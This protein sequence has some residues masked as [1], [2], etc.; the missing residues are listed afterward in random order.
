[1]KNLTGKKIE[2]SQLAVAFICIIFLLQILKFG[3]PHDVFT[4]DTWG[5]YLYLPQTFLHGDPAISDFSNIQYVLDNYPPGDPN[6]LYQIHPLPNGNYV[7]QYWCGVSLLSL[8][9]FYIGHFAAWLLSYP[10]DGYS[11]PYQFAFIAGNL[12]YMVIGILMF[13]KLLLQFFNPKITGITL[14]IICLGTNYFNIHITGLGMTHIYLFVLYTCT[15]YCIVRFYR[16]FKNK[17]LYLASIFL[18]LIILVRAVDGLLVLIPFTW[19]LRNFKDLKRRITQLWALRTPLLIAFIIGTSIL[20]IQFIYFKAISGSFFINSYAN[21]EESLYLDEPHLFEFLFSFRK[22]WFIYTP[23]MIFYVLGMITLFKKARG[24]FFPIIV[25]SI[26]FIYVSSSWSTWWYGYSF[27][28]R[29]M[30]QTYPLLAIPIGAFFSKYLNKRSSTFGLTTILVFLIGLNAFQT[31]QFKE[32][33]LHGSRMSFGA[34]CAIFGRL[35]KPENLDDLLLVNRDGAV[36]EKENYQALTDFK[37]IFCMPDVLDK[38]NIYSHSLMVPFNATSNQYYAWYEIQFE[39]KIEEGSNAELP[40]FVGRFSQGSRQY[41]TRQYQLSASSNFK[42][43][44]WCQ[45]TFQYI[46][47][48]IRRNSDN[49]ECFIWGRGENVMVKNMVMTS[50]V[51]KS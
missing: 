21:P 11:Y 35:T 10:M 36:F 8:P 39:F 16:T 3:L 37:T 38:E 44:E 4:W 28:Q 17:Y 19:G 47:P 41:G 51:E 14:I 30:I 1:M 5:Y 6:Y 46:T 23:I 24:L 49:F 9:F 22:G 13:R 34:Y 33:V 50:Y 31:Y 45:A 43:G 40:L 27:S 2:F 12:T 29:T 20:S 15:I 26:A 32:G 18:A 42:I 7:N 48:T 25:F